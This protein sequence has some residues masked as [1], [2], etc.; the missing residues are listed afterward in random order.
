[1]SGIALIRTEYLS[2]LNPC[3]MM[4]LGILQLTSVLEK[5][6]IEVIDVVDTSIVRFTDLRARL[7][8]VVDAR[9]EMIGL[10]TVSNHQPF[11]RAVSRFFKSRLPDTPIVLGGPFA[12][13]D[14]HGVLQ[15]AEVDM[16]V[17]GEGEEALPALIQALRAGEDYRS[18][19]GLIYRDDETVHVNPSH[20]LDIPL[21][22]LPFVAWDRVDFDYYGR[23]LS[24]CFRRSP[25]AAIMTSRGCPYNCIYCHKIFG[26]R[27]RGRSPDHVLEEMHLLWREY[28]LRR[29]EFVDD[30]FNFD[31]ARTVEILTRMRDELPGV[32]V[33]FGNGLRADRLDEEIFKLMRDVR[34]H[35]LPI[36][37]ETAVPHMQKVIGKNLD[38]SK[39]VEAAR[40][41]R[42][43]G[44]HTWG[45]FMIGFP[46]ETREEM[47]AT[48]DFAEAMDI[49]YRAI[50][51]SNPFEGTQLREML[52]SHAVG[53]ELGNVHADYTDGV[54]NSLN[55]RKLR[56]MRRQLRNPANWYFLFNIAFWK[57]WWMGPRQVISHAFNLLREGLLG[58][59]KYTVPSLEKER[60]E[61]LRKTLEALACDR[62]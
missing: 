7:E 5:K 16:A 49:D 61:V 8:R 47:E 58:R 19:P 42:K 54:V 30:I 35:F 57:L 62:G 13:A 12:S 52:G 38:I 14:P 1:M 32:R 51:T 22:E 3:V 45:F 9:P 44:I 2:M 59:R 15:R 37:V 60:A 6:G 34:C 46:G 33:G 41:A 24:M 36:P 48:I 18:I 4:P 39:A 53:S 31:H 25:F 55:D 23:F 43:Y 20:P 10:S 28:G 17:H 40:L 56:V 11:A 21:D 50:Q 27:F 29:F 26:N